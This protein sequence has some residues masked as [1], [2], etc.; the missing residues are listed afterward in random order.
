FQIPGFGDT[1]DFTEIKQHYFMVHTEI[2]PTKIV[3][4]GPDMSWLMEEHDRDRFGGQPFA[5]GTTMPGPL[6]KGEV[7]KNP[8]DFQMPLFERSWSTFP[9]AISSAARFA[10][11]AALCLSMPPDAYFRCGNAVRAPLITLLVSFSSTSDSRRQRCQ[12]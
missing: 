3:P 1:T 12:Y 10:V 9:S 8:A 11:C 4:V 7:V 6:P 5:E 2:N